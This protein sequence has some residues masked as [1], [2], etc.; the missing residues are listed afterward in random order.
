MTLINI[1][2]GRGASIRIKGHAGYSSGND[3]VC[4]A[5]SVLSFTL[6]QTLEKERKAGNLKFLKYDYRSGFVSV[7][8]LPSRRFKGRFKAILST[9]VSGFELLADRYP[10]NV[11]L[12]KELKRENCS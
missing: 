12:I 6:M 5:V 9:I 8:A 2:G 7:E 3:I 10:D 1:S 4:A 11:K